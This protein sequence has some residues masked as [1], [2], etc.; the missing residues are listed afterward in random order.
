MAI[1]VSGD[2]KKQFDRWRELLDSASVIVRHTSEAQAEVALTLIGEG[3]D[4]ET[5]PYGR[6]WASK[7]K[8]DGRKI[9]HGE[10]TRLR[11][12]WHVSKS[13]KGGWQVDPGVEYAAYHQ[14][15]RGGSR[16][17]RRMVPDASL[18]LP[19]EWSEEFEAVAIAEAMTHFAEAAD[20]SKPAV[21]KRTS[22]KAF[23]GIEAANDRGSRRRTRGGSLGGMLRQL[24]R[25]RSLAKKSGVL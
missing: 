12:G 19:K 7:K 13:T 22:N 17:T 3:F 5:D 2:F 16:P 4:R 14:E 15:P 10:T 8:D 1:K 21:K 23:T 6:K 9:L 18:G 25:L 20:G 24:R 11:N